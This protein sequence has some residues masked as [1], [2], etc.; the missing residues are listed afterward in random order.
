M[1]R[2][3]EGMREEFAD[4]REGR[5]GGESNK[6]VGLMREIIEKGGQEGMKK[7]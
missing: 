2:D 1:R 3:K 4:G 6:R 7:A 5:G